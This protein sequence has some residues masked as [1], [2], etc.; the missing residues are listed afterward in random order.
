[1][2]RYIRTASLLSCVVLAAGL[3]AASSQEMKDPQISLANPD[4]E[5]AAGELATLVPSSTRAETESREAR[6]LLSLS[7]YELNAATSSK[8][9]S[10]SESSIPV[11]LPFDTSAFVRDRT[12]AGLE[13]KAAR[14]KDYLFGFKSIS[15][16]DAGP[17]G[18]D[19]VVVAL[20]KDLG[21][22]GIGYSNPI[23]IHISGFSFL[24][25]VP[26]PTGLTELPI[27]LLEQPPTA[28]RVL[29]EDALRYSFVRYGVPYVISIE[30]VD[31]GS[32]YGRISC[33]DADRVAGRV[34][35]SLPL[36][37]G[38]PDHARAIVPVSL[39]HRPA[40][41]SNVFTYH[42]PGNLL[43]GTG[44]KNKSGTADYTVFSRI[45]FPLAHAPAF[46]NSQSFMNAG[47]CESTGWSG[48]GMRDGVAAY[49]CAAGPSP[50]A[51]ANV[52]PGESGKNNT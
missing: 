21:Q 43:P 17:G 14:N 7:L 18:Y 41:V 51:G 3:A 4:W 45:R 26:E 13:M 28:R 9:T 10:I 16:F 47:D 6:E 44:F 29:L 39:D 30:C 32:R 36:V 5:A 1:L 50:S 8:F 12:P 38:M 27:S 46:A 49:R 42:G 34:L 11:L 40:A 31:G 33:R 35:G 15:F 48:A 37:G 22:I 23:Y 24:Y 2:Q 52:G 19:A 25:D 20:A